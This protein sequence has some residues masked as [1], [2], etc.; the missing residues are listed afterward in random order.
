MAEREPKQNTNVV[1]QNLHRS[2]PTCVWAMIRMTWQYFFMEA[3][4]FSNCFLPSSSC[5]FLQYLVKAFFLDLYLWRP[6]RSGGRHKEKGQHTPFINPQWG[7]RNKVGPELAKDT[8]SHSR[9]TRGHSKATPGLPVYRKCLFPMS[10]QG[11]S[12][13]RYRSPASP[14][15]TLALEW[16][17]NF[18]LGTE[19]GYEQCKGQSLPQAASRG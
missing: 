15:F 6:E 11:D 8:W 12:T 18:R 16:N 2:R 5:H 7:Q 9:R 13:N 19:A 10:E 3:K 4:S 1:Q 17:P 14:G